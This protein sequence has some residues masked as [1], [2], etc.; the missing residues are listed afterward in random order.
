MKIYTKQLENTIGSNQAFLK[1]FIENPMKDNPEQN[2]NDAVRVFAN[3]RAYNDYVEEWLDNPWVRIAI[4]GIGFLNY[5][6]NRDVGIATFEEELDNGGRIYVLFAHPKMKN[7]KIALDDEVVR[8]TAGNAY[9]AFVEHSRNNA[10]VRV[11]ILGINE[12]T[13][14]GV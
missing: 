12:L 4:V 13:F 8:I 1:I 6:F 14:D 10:Y 5:I 9:N 3:G 2:I 7:P 11:V